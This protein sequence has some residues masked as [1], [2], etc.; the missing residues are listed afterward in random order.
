MK[1]RPAVIVL[2]PA[3]LIAGIAAFFAIVSLTGLGA[4][5]AAAGTIHAEGPD[6]GHWLMSTNECVSGQR[7]E[8]FGV[9]LFNSEDA[10]QAVKLVKPAV[11][12]PQAVINSPGK[13]RASL[14]MASDCKTFDLDLKRG[15]S[16]YNGIWNM[17]GRLTLDCN[18]AGNRVWGDVQME[19]CH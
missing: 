15:R 17:H 19:N 6:I 7:E 9:V 2:V 10:Q 11:G 4:P 3:L 16:A 5:P 12:L 1:V 14:F 8:F 13:H 18:I